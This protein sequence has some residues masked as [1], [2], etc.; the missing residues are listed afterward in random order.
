MESEARGQWGSRIGFVLAAIGSAV[1]LGNIW[2]FP[3]LTYKNGGGAF[4]IPY[5]IAVLTVGIPLIMLEV[6]L[7]HK[8]Q[9][10]APVAFS[11]ADK[12]FSWLGW[13]QPLNSLVIL[14]Y[15][16]VIIGWALNY[17]VFSFTQ[18]WGSDTNSFI[19]KSF[20]G[21]TSGPFDIGGIRWPIFIAMTVIWFLNWFIVYSGVQS[22][23]E[24]ANKIMMPLLFLMM[25]VLMIR[26]VTLPGA[27]VGLEQY[28][29]PDF[30]KILNAQVWID[31]FGQAFFSLSVA[32]GVYCAYG[33]YLPRKSDI[34]N[35]AFITGFADTGFA[36]LSG[37]AVFSI[38]GFM[39]TQS[40]VPFTEVVTQSIGLAFVAFPQGIG[41]M[42]VVPW[43][44]GLLFFGCLLFGGLTSSIS[45]VE[46]FSAGIIDKT[47]YN[48]K[49]VVTWT[50]FLGW[51]VSM[52][53]ATGAGLYI[54]DIVDHFINAYG[55]VL[56]GLAEAVAIGWFLGPE[57]LRQ[58]FNAISDFRIGPWW[59]FLIKYWA[60][61]IMIVMGLVNFAA[62]IQ[63]PYEGYPFLA[64]FLLGWLVVALV[65]VV[66]FLL[67]KMK[68][69][70]SVTTS[71]GG[72]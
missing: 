37:L 27:A 4:L 49:A 16:S 36:F 60:P 35:N 17:I 34:T 50:C 26:G 23:I 69:K 19:Y 64:L 51:L 33:S 9:G 56:A 47:G 8:S 68:P 41:M 5:L 30:S 25:L 31:A 57:K 32:M 53:F 20:L 18:A 72:V 21:I 3:Y 40:G 29:H 71:K 14:V 45:M 59:D 70:G 62:E 22:G 61:L 48:R 67:T 15:Y 13:W 52:V 12:R 11:K 10:S 63:K 66:A 28:L 42:P 54:L 6:S 58:H 44:F 2:R 7:G 55:V 46:S 43:L 65:L 24:R 1:G 38:L 39:S